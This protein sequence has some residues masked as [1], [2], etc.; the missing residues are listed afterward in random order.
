MKL[1]FYC[2]LK[3]Y[4]GDVN[5]GKGIKNQRVYLIHNKKLSAVVSTI[6]TFK[7]PETP[8]NI[9]IHESVIKRFMSKYHVLPFPFNTIAGEVIGKGVLYKYYKQFLENLEAIE[10]GYELNLW[11]SKRVNKNKRGDNTFKGLVR[12][13]NPGS[14]QTKILAA[15]INA[16]FSHLAQRSEFLYMVNDL[17]ILDGKYLIKKNNINLFRE[18]FGFCKKLYPELEFVMK[19]PSLPYS[20]NKVKIREGGLPY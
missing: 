10:N 8:S 1:Y 20:F 4:K 12:Q 15:K 7:Y 11:V 14:L 19:G 16:R 9:E 2:I 18:E 13:D 17:M 5:G 3:D 6:N